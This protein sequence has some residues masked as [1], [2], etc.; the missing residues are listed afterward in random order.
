MS[1]IQLIHTLFVLFLFV[2]PFYDKYVADTEMYLSLAFMFLF[3]IIIHWI[4][5]DDTCSLTYLESK[6]TGKSLS[7]TFVSRIIKP[8]YNGR[9]ASTMTWI[10]TLILLVFS[11]YQLYTKY[12][13]SYLYKIFMLI[14]NFVKRK[15]KSL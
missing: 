7:N 13:F 11:G 14:Q 4:L 2:T 10:V 1:Y 12:K 8:V 5:N 3:S 15:I 6:L 9:N